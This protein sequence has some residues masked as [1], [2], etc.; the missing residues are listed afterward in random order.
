MHASPPENSGTPT[1]Q[2][3]TRSLREHVV[4]RAH[5]ARLA[6]GGHLDTHAV[7]AMLEDRAVVRYPIGVRFDPGPLRRG[8]FACLEPLSERPIDGFCLWV[9]PRFADDPALLPVIIAYYIP[10]VNYG[11]V[12]THIEAELFGSTLLGVGREE[13][14]RSLCSAA[15]LVDRLADDPISEE[16]P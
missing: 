16:R 15:D 12:S 6:R 8:E 2:G 13:Y 9:H 3:A 11:D 10:S 4:D 5:R 14:Y 1:A 7:L